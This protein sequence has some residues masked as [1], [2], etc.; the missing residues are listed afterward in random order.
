M[1]QFNKNTHEYLANNKTLFEV[2]MLA[3]QEG[4]AI[5]GGNPTGT[6]VDAFG[7]MRIST[8]LTLFDSYNRYDQN[9]KFSTEAVSGG[10][11][12]YNADQSTVNMTVDGSS[13]SKVT[14]ESTRVF[15][16]QPG[17]S[18]LIYN[19][20][21]MEP[22]ST[23]L[24]Q[25]VGY[26]NDENGIFLELDDS[27]VK[28]TKRTNISGSP[29]EISVDQS[30]WSNDTL[31]GTGPS[32]VTLD[33]TKA[34]IFW[35]DIEWLGVGSVRCGF[36]IDGKV[37]HCHTFN[38]ANLIDS[39]YITTAILPIRY[40]IENTS[41][42]SAATLKQICSSVISEGGYEFRGSGGYASTGLTK[43]P[44]GS[45]LVPIISIRLNSSKLDAVAVLQGISATG[46]ASGLY[47][48]QLIRG[49]TL[50]NSSFS[51]STL[52]S[53][54]DVDTS[55]TAISGGN[56][57]GGN[58]AEITNQ[59]SLDINFGGDLFDLQLERDGSTGQSEIYTIAA[60][61]TASSA[62]MAACVNWQEVT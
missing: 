27:G 20:F 41:A 42:G 61:T 26:F 52:G 24:R 46:D 55:A 5:E 21:V 53:C 38:H 39:T 8:P 29:V 16:Y 9:D 4:N 6:A 22:Q 57:L 14:R 56:I 59:S 23:G 62:Q 3:D 54:V 7:R 11:T 49:A 32:G 34:Q 25:R 60:R 2:V 45:T 47:E 44:V 17:K 48:L 30:A 10:S 12:S 33:I 58:I 35:M 50:T 15:A 37:L 51:P 28:L 31:L 18:L 43:K 40:E 36:V 1:A 13:G 19:T